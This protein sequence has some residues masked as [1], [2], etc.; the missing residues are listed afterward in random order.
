[1]LSADQAEQLVRRLNQEGR[2][3]LAVSWEVCLLHSLSRVGVVSHEF[4]LEN[5]RRPDVRFSHSRGSKVEFIADITAISDQGLHEANPIE[6][7]SEELVRLARAAGLDPDHLRYDVRGQHD[8]PYGFQKTV[9]CLPPRAEIPA[10]LQAR[11]L[12]FF[13]EIRDRGLTQYKLTIKEDRISITIS[14]GVSQRYMGGGYPSYNIAQSL[15]KNPLWNQLKNKA[16]QLSAAASFAP[17]GIIVCDG[18]CLLLQDRNGTGTFPSSAI[19]CKFLKENSF[20]SFVLLL[21]VREVNASSHHGPRCYELTSDFF[22]LRQSTEILQIQRTFSDAVAKLP[23]PVLDPCNAYIQC[24]EK[25][26]RH[27]HLGGYTLSRSLVR[28]SARALLEVFAGRLTA[29]EFNEVHGWRPLAGQGRGV[30]N[31]FERCLAEGRMITQVRV[32]ATEDESDDWLTIQFGDPDPAI[33]PFLVKR[34]P[35]G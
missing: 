20:I 9:L 2:D 3:R 24:R 21:R 33:S 34:K 29:S 16:S 28:I 11:V 26:Y 15:K 14:Y 7:F 23:R 19:I 5:G 31:P 6:D 12:P 13:E 32:E 30:I 17:A 1:V 4:P 18:G 10:F 25:G 35:G 27:G 8:G 22:S